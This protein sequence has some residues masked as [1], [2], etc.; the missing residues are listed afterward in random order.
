MSR[1]PRTD[2]VYS[3]ERDRAGSQFETCRQLE[4]E[5]ALHKTALTIAM[6]YVPQD[7]R[8]KIREGLARET[9]KLGPYERAVSGID[10]R[11]CAQL[12]KALRSTWGLK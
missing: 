7:M 12:N 1:T 4:H 9:P 11:A 3:L 6:R 8:T 10:E 2:K 5:L